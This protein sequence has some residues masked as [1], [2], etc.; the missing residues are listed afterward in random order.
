[1]NARVCQV[2]ILSISCRSFTLVKVEYL[3]IQIATLLVEH[4]SCSKESQ[5]G[6][7]IFVV[8]VLKSADPT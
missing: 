5:T 2:C 8:I 7:P 3:F 1:M 4:L 6:V